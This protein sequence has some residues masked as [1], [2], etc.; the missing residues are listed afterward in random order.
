MKPNFARRSL[1]T[2]EWVWLVIGLLSLEVIYSQ[3]N[4]DRNKAYMFV[5]FA[6]LG[7]FMF[8]LRRKQ[9]KSMEARWKSNDDAS[10]PS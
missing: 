6:F 2:V 4:G 10:H 1:K 5:L 9:R 7:F 8:G 3:W